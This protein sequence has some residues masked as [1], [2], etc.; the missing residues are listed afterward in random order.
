MSNP[1]FRMYSEAVDDEK[2]GLVSFED[3]WHFVALLCCKNSGI[4]DSD[5]SLLN[6]KVA[7]KLK[8]DVRELGEVA[9]RLSEV[10]LIDRETLQ[11]LRWEDRQFKSDSS[12]ERVAAYRD[13]KK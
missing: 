4:L 13:R 9:R 11:P 3:R 12:I 10:G 7:F 2:L 1:W 6:R 5:P 8:L